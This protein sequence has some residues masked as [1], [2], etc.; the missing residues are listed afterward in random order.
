VITPLSDY[1]DIA[2]FIYFIRVPA[3]ARAELVAFLEARGIPTGIHLQA[4][5]DFTFYSQPSEA[6][7]R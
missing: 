4:A 7:C 6:I 5:Y 2:P 1:K 3:G